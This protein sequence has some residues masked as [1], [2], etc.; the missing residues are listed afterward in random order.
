MRYLLLIPLFW[1]FVSCNS[2]SNNSP[3]NTN[4]SE[5]DTCENFA[6]Y[7]NTIFNRNTN[8]VTVYIDEAAFN[9]HNDS[10]KILQD[11]LFYELLEKYPQGNLREKIICSIGRITPTSATAC[12]TD[13]KLVVGDLA[14]MLLE[15][16]ENLPRRKMLIELDI[17]EDNCFLPLGLFDAIDFRR[18]NL[19]NK[20]MKY[21]KG[22]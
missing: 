4:K 19:K 20:T 12:N 18:E 11:S 15:K 10:S 16:I 17:V 22:N 21:I 14:Y 9:W 1:C 6:F 3:I 13:K 8:V 5:K 7:A 2:S